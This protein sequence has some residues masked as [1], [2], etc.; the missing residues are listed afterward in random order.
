MDATTL[1]TLVGIV[2]IVVGIIGA[3]IG[4]IGWRSLQAAETNNRATASNGSTINQGNTY[5]YGVSEETVRLIA[6]N[7]T[8]EQMCQLV[9]RL[10][11][12]FTDDENCIG[13]RLRNGTITADDFDNII[14]EIPTT[15]YGKTPP[16]DFYQQKS[17]SVWWNIDIES[18]ISST[19]TL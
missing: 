2:G 8:L 10:I 11:P 16:P 3:V 13:N 19:G 14:D 1:N 7:M 12:I 4:V 6:K 9:I 15:Y 5:H 17:G 18:P